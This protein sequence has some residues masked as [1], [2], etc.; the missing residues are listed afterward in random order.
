MSDI[1]WKKLDARGRRQVT[2]G[3]HTGA[4]E[5]LIRTEAPLTPEQELELQ[6]AGYE[7]RSAAGDVLSGWIADTAR[8]EEIASLP[9]VRKIEL[10]RPMYQEGQQ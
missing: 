6:Q 9:F 2:E 4:V 7:I 8:L 5:A 1:L 3:I 10:S